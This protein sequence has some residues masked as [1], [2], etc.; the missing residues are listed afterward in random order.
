METIDIN[1]LPG[2]KKRKKIS[3][4]DRQIISIAIL[5]TLLLFA[6]YGGILY[7]KHQKEVKLEELNTRINALKS[8]QNVLDI[9]SS[10][11]SKLLYYENSIKNYTLKQSDWNALI[12]DVAEVLPKDTRISQIDADK[13]TMLVTV[14][15][16]TKNLQTLAWTVYAFKNSDKFS[17]VTVKNYTVPYGKDASQGNK[18]QSTTFTI[19]FKWKGMKR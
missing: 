12:D 2:R 13:K 3:K 14:T 6:M 4:E 10:L 7:I 19:T 15:G 17:N 8:V 18:N 11:G 9:R 1:L 16:E 5:V